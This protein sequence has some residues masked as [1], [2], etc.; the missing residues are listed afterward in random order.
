MRWLV[1]LIMLALVACSEE[2]REIVDSSTESGSDPKDMVSVSGKW[3]FHRGKGINTLDLED[4]EGVITGTVTIDPEWGGESYPIHGTRVDR[5]VELF[6]SS[7]LLKPES[8][9]YKSQFDHALSGDFAHGKISG[10]L[11]T[12]MVSYFTSGKILRRTDEY[13]WV[14]KRNRSSKKR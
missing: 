4:D 14:A 7:E 10:S 13:L 1:I 12:K 8:S 6:Y 5:A 9:L 3:F 2:D 11:E